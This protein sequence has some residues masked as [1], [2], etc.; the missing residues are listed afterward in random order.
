MVGHT[1][2]PSES[3]LVP[4]VAGFPPGR[5]WLVLAPHADDEALGIGATLALAAARGVE[6][7]VVVVTDGGRQGDPA[8]REAEAIAAAGVLGIAAPTFWRLPDRSLAGALPALR[9]AI[10]GALEAS[11]PDAVLVTSPVDLHPDHRAVAIATQRAL[12]R[13]LLLGLRARPPQWVVAYEVGSLLQPNLLVA[14]DEGWERKRRAV[15]CYRSQ[16]AAAPYERV[17]EGLAAVRCLTLVGC[18]R[19]EAFHVL[20]ARTVARSSARGWAAQMGS[21]LGVSPRRRRG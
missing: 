2:L 10:A 6:V 5:R 8:E 4:Y 12:R 16:L 13:R 7:E 19:A 18:T 17:M 3:D 9:G 1:S 14:A 20:P 21:P 11:A 15:A